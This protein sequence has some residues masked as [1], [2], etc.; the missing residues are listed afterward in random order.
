MS[1]LTF[2]VGGTLIKYALMDQTGTMLAQGKV[3]T[4]MESQEAFLNVIE[5]VA[6]Q[7]M[8]QLEGIALSLPGTIDSESGWIFQGGSLRYHSQTNLKEIMEERFHLPVEIENDARCAA[9]AEVC[10]GNMKD[11]TNGIVL[12][13]GTGIGGCFILNNEIYKGSHLFSGEVS[14]LITKD[15]KT[16]GTH[17]A[18]G[19]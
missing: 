17:A 5:E 4:P 3:P 15:I 2:D 16:F 1:I 13:F 6:S 10:A 18:W 9:L 19:V 12:V 14:A 7:W 8:A 11:I